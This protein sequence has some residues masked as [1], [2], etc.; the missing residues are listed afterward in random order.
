M[1][2]DKATETLKRRL[3]DMGLIVNASAD[4]AKSSKKSL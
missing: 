3:Q 2:E 4:K 1:I